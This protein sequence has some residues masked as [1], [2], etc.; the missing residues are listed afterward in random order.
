MR[1]FAA[2]ASFAALAFS[3]VASA[4]PASTVLHGINLNALNVMLPDHHSDVG[5]ASSVDDVARDYES[6][7]GIPDVLVIL[8]GEVVPAC[9]DLAAKVTAEVDVQAAL[10][11]A[12]E[13]FAHIKGL[14]TGAVA[15]IEVI[16]DGDIGSAFCF[17]GKVLELKV[18]AQI[19]ADLV[20]AVVSSLGVAVKACAAVDVKALLAVAVDI[21]GL[22]A[23]IIGHALQVNGGILVLLVPLIQPVVQACVALKL[24]AIIDV[25]HITF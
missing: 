4:L 5:Y 11:L 22:L 20:L 3:A 21:S 7:K 18:V 15:D 9:Q 10:N 16:V 24:T 23:A 25:L 8:V 17:E 13:G 1:S 2:I 19:L 14:L 6:P 12:L